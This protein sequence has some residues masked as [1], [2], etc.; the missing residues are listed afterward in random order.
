MGIVYKLLK[1]IN[2]VCKFLSINLIQLISIYDIFY[3][4]MT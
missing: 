1:C 4:N 3:N 2:V